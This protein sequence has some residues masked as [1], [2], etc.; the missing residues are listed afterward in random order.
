MMISKNHNGFTLLETLAALAIF[1]LV[2]T[3]LFILESSLI[4]RVSTSTRTTEALIAAKNF[5]YEARIEW[6]KKGQEPQPLEKNDAQKNRNFRYSAQKVAQTSALK[7]IYGLYH[8]R[9]VVDW[10]DTRGKQTEELVA[11][12]VVPQQEKGGQ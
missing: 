9:V 1:A 10:K 3:P 6:Q 2:A 12:I 4:E 5:L 7:S 11:F 8:E